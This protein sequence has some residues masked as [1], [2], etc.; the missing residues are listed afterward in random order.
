MLQVRKLVL[1]V[2]AATA[3]TS[4]AAHALSLGDVSVKSY[5]GQP[6]EAEIELTDIDGLDSTE[7]RSQLASLEEFARHGIERQFFLSNIKFTPVINQQGKSYIR[8][9][10]ER[11][12]DEPYVSFLLELYWPSGRALREYTI[13][14]DPPMYSPHPVAMEPEAADTAEPVVTRVEREA[15]APVATPVAAPARAAERPA[16]K[17]VEQPATQRRPAPA[18]PSLATGQQHS[19]V[20]NESLWSIASRTEGSGN[21]YQKMIAIVEQNPHAFINNDINKLRAGAVLELPTDEQIRRNSHSEAL[22]QYQDYLAG[23]AVAASTAQLDARQLDR[24]AA[25]PAT[26]TTEDSLRLLA[27]ETGE[28]ETGSDSGST[29]DV[30]QLTTQLAQTKEQLDSVQLENSD[31]RERVQELD[32]QLERLQKLVELKNT[33]LANLQ[34]MD[35]AELQDDD[36]TA[37]AELAAE[38]HDEQTGEDATSELIAADS[39]TQEEAAQELADDQQQADSAVADAAPE[40]VAAPAEPAVREQAEPA[41]ARPVPPVFEDEYYSQSFL[42]EML[43]NPLFLPAAGG[44]ALVAL[45]L[46]LLVA[47]R[48]KAAKENAELEAE[49]LAYEK[50][51]GF[52]QQPDFAREDEPVAAFDAADDAAELDDLEDFNIP[53]SEEPEQKQSFKQEKTEGG[54]LAQVEGY[55]AYGRFNEAASMLMQAI[56]AEP[57]RSDLRFKLLEVFADLD[58]RNGFERQVSELEEMGGNQQQLDE[59]KERFPDM[60][61]DPLASFMPEGDTALD[62]DSLGL[63][64]DGFDEQPA[65]Q[66]Q[67]EDE[68]LADFEFNDLEE[69]PDAP[70]EQQPVADTADENELNLDALDEL[71]FDEPAI[72]EPEPEPEPELD[73]LSLTLSELDQLDMPEASTEVAESLDFGLLDQFDAEPSSAADSGT[74]EKPEDDAPDFSV[75]LDLALAENDSGAA[76]ESTADNDLPE[77]DDDFAALNEELDSLADTLTPTSADDDLDSLLNEAGELDSDFELGSLD[78]DLNLDGLDFGEPEVAATEETDA[79]AELD[80]ESDLGGLDEMQETGGLDESQPAYDTVDSASLSE[81]EESLGDDFDFLAGTDETTTKLDLARAYVDMGDAD[82][83]RDILE[84]VMSEGNDEQKQQAQ[85]LM[86]KLG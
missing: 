54:V 41:P 58:D 48:R 51:H 55:I 56:D 45:L 4:G 30:R 23:P 59:F 53:D 62:L 32:E 42:D 76:R 36:A 73:E 20:K 82:G 2:A 57:E 3:F 65:T 38:V 83:A 34:N 81:L 52:D 37:T 70:A 33:Q 19:V 50:Q 10:S 71:S 86:K 1:A 77:L 35:V 49:N 11:S 43:A 26:V 28:S 18:R 15:Q 67:S 17:P 85:E 12:I 24:A 5:L 16:A 68:Q 25:A 40:P 69:Q 60:F 64:L 47:R 61:D 75:D 63:G 14:M 80:L 9:T 46:L 66:Q 21:I 22:A 6:L 8:V 78:T 7:V 39:E 29:S 27:S 74:D 44:S 79:L 72:A 13:L 31:L 84:E